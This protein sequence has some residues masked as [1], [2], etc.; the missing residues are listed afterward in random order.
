MGKGE[1]VLRLDR[2]GETPV[3]VVRCSYVCVWGGGLE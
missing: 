3:S 2:G 1:T